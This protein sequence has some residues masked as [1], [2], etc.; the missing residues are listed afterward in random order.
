MNT[1][2]SLPD[3][4]MP[5]TIVIGIA[6][7]ALLGWRVFNQSSDYVG[8]PIQMKSTGAT[9]RKDLFK[10]FG[11]KMNEIPAPAAKSASNN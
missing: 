8:P 7:I 10:A 2:K 5:V 1:R 6:V 11:Q 4:A 3:W 9:F